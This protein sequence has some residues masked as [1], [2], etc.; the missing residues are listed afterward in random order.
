MVVLSATGLRRSFGLRQVLDG[1]SLT[2]DLGERV[3]L[4]GV[5]GSGKSTL[6]RIL[7]G[8]DHADAGT[9]TSRKDVTVGYLAQVPDLPRDET[10]REI[11]LGGLRRWSEARARYER[12]AER[13]TAGTGDIE[14]LLAEQAQASEDIEQAGGWELE[15]EADAVLG[16]VGITNLDAPAH[17]LS[18]GELRR[19]ALA[20]LLVSQ[21]TLAILDEPTNHLDVDTIEWLEQYL[22]TRFKGAL[23]LITHDRYLLD[24]VVTRT[25]EIERGQL[26]SYDGGYA[27]FLE[28]K[29]EREALAE[30]TEAN[31]RNFLRTELEWLRRQPKARTTKSKSRIDRAESA[32]AATPAKGAGKVQ[33][34]A[35]VARSGHMILELAGLGVEVPG[36][37]LV[38]DLDLAL[39]QGERIG[40][41]GP[42]GAGKSTLLRTIL[43][44]QPPAAGTVRLGKNARIAYLDQTRSG[45]RPEATVFEAVAGNR[46]RV[47]IGGQS[48]EFRAYLERFM[49]RGHEQQQKVGSLSGGERARVALARI[50]SD[51]AN[52]LILDE[53]TNDLDVATLGALEQL[54][55][56]FGGTCLV[57]THDRYF[58]DRIATAI[59]AFEGDGQV[60][61]YE[62]DYSSYLQRRPAQT[63]DSAPTP[64]TPKPARAAPTRPAGLT[65]AERKELAGLE[66]R[67]E[68]AE[69]R[70]AELQDALADPQTYADGPAKGQKL[71]EEL[72]RARADLEALMLRWET[73]EAK[74][75]SAAP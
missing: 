54:I 56:E 40:I 21:P 72:G 60:T 35:E 18:G 5:N 9:V 19:V 29:A 16:H 7:A 47:E 8:A 75:E 12:I 42:N 64:P 71:G 46:S 11:V 50:L 44:E 24:N 23:L 38:R 1:V 2:I 52:L 39:R 49:F 25:C 41:V 20:R 26:H 48:L 59:V 33:L 57:V 10:A 55:V 3:G 30:R 74:Q 70:V 63:R 43:G 73:L 22:D 67:I 14:A 58:L 6:G 68:A 45:L 15:H 28:A 27:S 34:Q 62:G 65:G 17:T 36:R 32:L 53:P 37:R 4:L 51:P 61:R 13:L 66:P 31:R 69:S